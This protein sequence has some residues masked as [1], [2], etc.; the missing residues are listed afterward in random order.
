[1]NLVIWLII[2]LTS[3]FDGEDSERKSTWINPKDGMEFTWIPGGNLKVYKDNQSPAEKKINGFYIGKY[4]VTVAQFKKFIEET[5]YVTEA[6]LAD[7]IHT[8]KNPG[9][10]Q[11]KNH[12][13]IYTSYKDALS[14]A[15]WAGV[16]LPGEAQWLYACKGGTDKKYGWSN[17]I[18]DE[19]VWHRENS[20]GITHPVNSKNPNALGLYHMIGNA[21]EWCKF[22]SNDAT[23]EV[24]GVPRGGSWTRC[25]QKIHYDIP[26]PPS[27]CFPSHYM[28]KWDDD[29]GF[30]C[31]YV[32]D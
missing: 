28:L 3:I 13:V 14:Y 7:S 29:R 19:Y 24:R 25:P 4:E 26:N 20:K 1:M 21:Y 6:E 9:I 16:D 12:P 15:S 8:W 18:Q 23:C 11:E 5:S 31:M 2:L 30:R 17:E 22:E 10:K 32:P 27:E